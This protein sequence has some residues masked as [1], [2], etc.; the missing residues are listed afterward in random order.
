[1]P[2]QLWYGYLDESG[3]VAPFTGSRHLIVTILLTPNA[4]PIELHVK[5]ARMALG[6]KTRPDEMKATAVETTVVQR[7]L[8]AIIDEN[9]EIIAVVADKRAIRRP[10]DDP[11]DIYREVMAQAVRICVERHPH[12]DLWFD[13]RYTKPT[14][15][16]LLE[17]TIRDRIADIPQQAMLLY[18]E[19]SQRQRGLQ[20][21]DHV[22]W[23]FYQ[24][25][26]RDD[27]RFYQILKRKI[28]SE[29]V[30]A[31][32]VVENQKAVLPGP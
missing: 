25:Y 1:M 7:L 27:D 3:D 23:A 9:T 6:R 15:R 20:A 24:K 10:P 2:G 29:E 26:E 8:Q 21:V 5:R 22:A 13:K 32:S 17:K 4:R 18:Q 19:D 31:R 16:H 14:L 11:E 12:V 28:V 30:L